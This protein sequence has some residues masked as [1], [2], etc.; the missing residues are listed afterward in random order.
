VDNFEGQMRVGRGEFRFEVALQVGDEGTRE[1]PRGDRVKR[2]QPPEKGRPVL[3]VG[4]RAVRAAHRNTR[5][6]A[7]WKTVTGRTSQQMGSLCGG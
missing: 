2:A 3:R 6:S 4:H 7:G 5:A 1:V